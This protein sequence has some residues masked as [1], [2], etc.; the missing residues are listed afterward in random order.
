MAIET[1]YET[2]TAEYIMRIVLYSKLFEHIKIFDHVIYNDR[3]PF[4]FMFPTRYRVVVTIQ[5]E[6][7]IYNMID[8]KIIIFE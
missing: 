1:L 7:S 8:I 6:I 3:P 2:E 5:Q 4:H